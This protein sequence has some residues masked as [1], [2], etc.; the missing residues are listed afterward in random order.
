MQ[1]KYTSEDQFVFV[2]LTYCLSNRWATLIPI[3]KGIPQ[4]IGSTKLGRGICRR[5]GPGQRPPNPQPSP[6]RIDPITS[7]KST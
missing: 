1:N 5:K 2:F 7:L 4:N 6:N 3:T